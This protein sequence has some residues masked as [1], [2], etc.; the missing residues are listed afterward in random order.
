VRGDDELAATDDDF[1]LTTVRPEEGAIGDT[2][3]FDSENTSGGW[4]RLLSFSFGTSLDG[5]L[6][7]VLDIDGASRVCCVGVSPVDLDTNGD[8][9]TGC[10]GCA[11]CEATG[12]TEPVPT[13]G[14][15][16]Y[17]RGIRS[18]TAGFEGCGRDNDSG[19][20]R[21]APGG[22]IGSVVVGE[23]ADLPDFERAVSQA[24]VAGFAIETLLYCGSFGGGGGCGRCCCG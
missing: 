14:V 20:F 9:F 6:E 24:C 2:T 4:P 17:G 12:L 1:E 10:V 21:R 23:G 13:V 15:R 22:R 19:L 3:F 8:F 16:A 7:D 11:G 18:G 5:A